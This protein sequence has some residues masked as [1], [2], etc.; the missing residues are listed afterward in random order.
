MVL[1]TVG[2]IVTGWAS[3]ALAKG[4][5]G[6]TIT[7]PDLAAPIVLDLGEPGSGERLSQLADG[8]GLYLAMFGGS[9]AALDLLSAPPAGQLGPKYEIAYHVPGS[10]APGELVRQEL[11]PLASVGPVTY[12]EPGQAVFDVP[13]AGGWYVAP[14]SFARLLDRLGV[15]VAAAQ[16]QPDQPGS[17]QEVAA[18]APAD[19]APRAAWV[20][21]VIAAVSGVLLLLAS[22]VIVRRR[23]HA[24][25][26]GTPAVR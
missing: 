5:D 8:S 2:L 7:G 22:A 23:L 21:I 18:A 25:R 4:A 16:A 14:A 15:P 24:V 26:R 17:Q 13:A 19:P 3:P 9:E 20:G 1:A 12:T 6:A 10:G 11:Y